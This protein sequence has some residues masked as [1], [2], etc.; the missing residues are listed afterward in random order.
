MVHP[1]TPA[2]LDAGSLFA[3]HADQLLRYCCG[4]LPRPDAE[5]VVAQTFLVAH[6]RLP[7]YRP[8]GAGVRAWLF[9]IATNLVREHRRAE[10]RRLRALARMP[11]ERSPAEDP[12]DRAAAISS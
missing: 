11:A 1:Q 8:S 9:G 6:R 12:A 5:D 3:E 2:S 7:A 4:R 10:G